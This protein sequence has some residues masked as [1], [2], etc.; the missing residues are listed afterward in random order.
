MWL[1]F[2]VPKKNRLG[3]MVLCLLCGVSAY[4]VECN[5]SSTV[6]ARKKETKQ[7]MP[8]TVEILLQDN[9]HEG[10]HGFCMKSI[11]NNDIDIYSP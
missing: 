7:N 10:N 1:D 3:I 6:V 4:V 5:V 11:I 8:R 9:R 2:N